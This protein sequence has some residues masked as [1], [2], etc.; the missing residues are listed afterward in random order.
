MPYNPEIVWTIWIV[1]FLVFELWAA[2]DQRKG[3]TLSETVGDWIGVPRWRRGVRKLAPLRRLVLGL[4]LVA[5]LAHLVW[6]VSV[7]PVIVLGIALGAVI[8]WGICKEK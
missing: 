7:G 4:F 1:L 2:L 8:A 3:N 6:G 5:L